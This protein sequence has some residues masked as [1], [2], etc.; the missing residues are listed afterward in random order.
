MIII[1]L[2]HTFDITSVETNLNNLKLKPFVLRTKLITQNK[3]FL[4]IVLQSWIKN[5]DKFSTLVIKKHNTPYY[6]AIL[7]IAHGHQH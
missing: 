3:T 6:I 2:N 7:S 1:K 5:F 4:H